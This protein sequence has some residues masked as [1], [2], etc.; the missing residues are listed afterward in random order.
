[1]PG[2]RRRPGADE[3]ITIGDFMK[4]LFVHKNW[5]AQFGGLGRFLR[6]SGWEVAFATQREGAKSDTMRI[7]PFE[8]HRTASTG[9][10]PY[11]RS[12]E[13]AVIAGQGLARAAVTLS[14]DGWKPD[15]IVSHSGWV[16]GA[17]AKSVWPSAAFVP[18]FEWF[19]RFP[20]ADRTAYDRPIDAL[21]ASARSRVR[22]LPFMLDFDAADIGLVPT[23][24]QL[25]QFP[26]WMRERLV[27]MHDGIDTDLHSP[28]SGGPA[29]ARYGIPE[30]AELVTSLARGMEPHRG[31]PEIMRCIAR[32][33]KRRPKLYAV[34]VGE[35][36]VAYGSK[37][38]E[39]D[40]WKRRM[41]DELDLDLAR[42]SFPGRIPRTEMVDLMRASDAHLYVTVPFVLSWSMLE[43][44]SVG[45]L[46]V[47]SDVA[48]VR[49]FVADGRTGLLVPLNDVDALAARIEFALD[50]RDDLKPLREAARRLVL[51][52]LDAERILF[53]RKRELL[54]SL[55]EGKAIVA[56][57][58]AR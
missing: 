29:R 5:P 44:M 4:V 42:I 48:P 40:S 2:F 28:G 43:A 47:A 30:D 37:L 57:P 33:Q 13:D 54:K 7:V 18:Y 8:S 1:M 19:Y 32:L 52:Q 6:S 17:F 55:V 23:A 3:A 49:E 50:S 51:E 56:P 11:L 27:V 34:I 24:Y 46:L 53:P 15:I 38:P 26:T 10:H 39:G 36:R 16:T 9:T 58:A 21:E 20:A 12:L 41:L 22:N 31:F 14:R 45:C 35:D 25:E